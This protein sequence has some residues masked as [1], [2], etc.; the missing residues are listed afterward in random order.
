MLLFAG[1]QAF[2]S[3][4]NS[5]CRLHYTIAPLGSVFVD[6]S[7]NA[8]NKNAF[9]KAFQKQFQKS[10]LKGKETPLFPYSRFLSTSSMGSGNLRKYCLKLRSTQQRSENTHSFLRTEKATMHF[11]GGQIPFN[12]AF[13]QFPSFA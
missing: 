1:C 3:F 8:F 9:A 4:H 10:L 5:H 12:A 2:P 13:L 6:L 7:H 11:K